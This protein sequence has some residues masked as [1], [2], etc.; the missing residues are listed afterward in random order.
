VI[1]PNDMWYKAFA[2]YKDDG[3]MHRD[4]MEDGLELSGFLRPDLEVVSDAFNSVSE[5]YVTLSEDQWIDFIQ[6]YIRKQR[7]ANRKAFQKCDEDGSGSVEV[8]EL[9]FL[10]KSCGIEPMEHVLKEVLGEVDGDGTGCL[11]FQE[12]E[13]LMDL[14]RMREGFTLREYTDFTTLFKKFDRD[15][16][17][18][19]DALE[20]QSILVWLGY[21]FD[22]DK[23]MAVVK[24]V[25]TN[26][27]GSVNLRE[28]LVCMR[29]VREQ[30]IEV[31]H[32]V[33]ARTDIDGD[34]TISREELPGVLQALGYVPEMNAVWES[35]KEAG[36]FNCDNFDFGELWQL[37]TTYRQREGFLASEMEEIE[38]GFD[39][40]D[41]NRTGE[42][43]HSEV[44]QVLRWLGYP[45]S[46]EI[47]QQLIAKVDIDGS[48]SLSL[49]EL[50]KLIRIYQSREL[51]KMRE[52]FAAN[53]VDG[54]G[55]LTF[56]EAKDALTDL[57]CISDKGTLPKVSP[58]DLHPE[59][60]KAKL[61]TPRQSKTIS[62]M[63]LETD[64][65]Y[66]ALDGFVRT[67]VQYQREERRR[68]RDNGGFS[69]EEVRELKA[70]FALYDVDKSGDIGRQELVTLIEEAFPSMA[71]D[72]IVRPQLA[73]MI[74]DADRDGSG[75]LDFRDF[76][77]LMERLR[78]LEHRDQR[79]K[80]KTAVA[81]T[82]FSPREVEEFRE[83]FLS[84]GN[85]NNLLSA[86]ELREML[87]LICPLGDKN[88]NE[89]NG[90]LCSVVTRDMKGS[91]AKSPPADVAPS[92]IDFPDFICL[93]NRLLQVNF[94][95]I[96]ERVS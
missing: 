73:R 28:F 76:M 19:M 96:K 50:L 33:I 85:G 68:F 87:C 49:A 12:F 29:K 88:T 53:E 74:K 10:L 32:G 92:F 15:G 84:S 69:S 22:R 60:L 65:P 55:Y 45:T 35:A 31:I 18:E 13:L 57:R 71:H 26:C 4:S 27:S 9:K 75:S 42:I 16:S 5:H 94:A 82:G 8:G 30:E 90:H 1:K 39:R 78:E 72:P 37:L 38:S 20:L 25:D 83:L 48:G 24:E 95:G 56:K 21:N 79:Q 62:L 86:E 23:T 6:V 47:L 54:R 17:G 40:Y 44:G 63:D 81:E 7:E 91:E 64:D 67:V 80:E 41:K 89:L 52:A 77:A 43:S 34:G 70:K 51:V 14:L 61:L 11:N 59:T 93:M 58:Q 2:K 66:V 36:V 3:Q 46:F